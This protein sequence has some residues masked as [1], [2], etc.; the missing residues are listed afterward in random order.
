MSRIINTDLC[1]NITIAPIAEKLKQ[2]Q[3]N[4]YGHVMRRPTDHPTSRAMNLTINKTR[5][6]VAPIY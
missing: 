1:K 6:K 5:P 3:L 4:W 2:N